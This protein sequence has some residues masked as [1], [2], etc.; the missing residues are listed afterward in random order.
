MMTATGQEIEVKFY[1]GNLAALKQKLV[2]RDAVLVQERVHE[3]NL[4]FDTPERALYHAGEML[5]LRKDTEARMTFKGAGAVQA[6]ARLR[7]ELEFMVD[8]FNMA[9]QVLESLGFE[10][11]MMY[12]KY[13]AVYKLGK[14]LVTL[15]EMPYGD[16]AEIEGPDG[17]TI[18]EAALELGLDWDARSL[19]SYTFLFAKVKS[20][21]KLAFNDLSF[22]NFEGIRVTGED[23]GVIIAD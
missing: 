19:D 11:C 5:R 15:D 6:G 13:R 1:I 3:V 9:R 8:D 16:F 20:A 2:E 17:E 7:Q 4:R 14:V 18:Q 12:E 22:E 10:V 23:L 21:L